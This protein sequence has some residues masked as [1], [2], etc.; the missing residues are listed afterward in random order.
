MCEVPSLAKELLASQGGL[1]SM[2]IVLQNFKLNV[3]KYIREHIT[4]A[5]EIHFGSSPSQKMVHEWNRQEEELEKN[6]H[7]SLTH[8]MP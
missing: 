4:E 8:K 2:E 6:K 7:F 3:I 1:C 5:A